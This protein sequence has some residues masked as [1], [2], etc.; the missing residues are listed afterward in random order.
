M[1]VKIEKITK[2]DNFQ[3]LLTHK[4]RVMVKLIIF[5]IGLN[6]QY[7]FDIKKIELLNNSIYPGVKTVKKHGQKSQKIAFFVI[8]PDFRLLT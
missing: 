2:N 5:L 7:Q 1:S 6:T 4:T 3:H 8:L